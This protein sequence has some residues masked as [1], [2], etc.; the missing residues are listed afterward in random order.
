M[1]VTGEGHSEYVRDEKVKVLRCIKP[2][3]TDDV[4]LGQYT[5]GNGNELKGNEK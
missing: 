4:I 3:T 5:K 2:L 1:K